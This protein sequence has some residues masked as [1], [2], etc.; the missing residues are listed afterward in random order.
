MPAVETP[1]KSAHGAESVV[2]MGSTFTNH[3]PGAVQTRGD[4]QMEPM[5]SS[6]SR[7]DMSDLVAGSAA[8]AHIQRDVVE[9]LHATIEGADRA[10]RSS[11][12]C[13][14]PPAGRR[15]SDE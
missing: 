15:A 4:S 6:S 11:G 2:G 13:G 3:L 14:G 12:L 7:A 1:T 9:Q 10:A 8:P 5:S